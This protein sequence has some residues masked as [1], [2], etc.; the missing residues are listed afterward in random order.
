MK[1]YL[2]AA[3][4]GIT[5]SAVSY[6]GVTKFTAPDLENTDLIKPVS[7]ID[8]PPTISD[9]L[10]YTLAAYDDTDAVFSALNDAQAFTEPRKANVDEITAFVDDLSSGKSGL[11]EVGVECRST[12][13][14][15]Q[16]DADASQGEW[17]ADL[18]GNMPSFGNENYVYAYAN[19]EQSTLIMLTY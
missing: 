3:V 12:H 13:C 18:A 7:F 1:Y 2:L 15:I 19:R 14:I 6:Y 11:R 16:I 8:Y 4:L 9:E 5:I 17:L 10:S